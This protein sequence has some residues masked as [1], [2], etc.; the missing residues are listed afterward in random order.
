MEIEAKLK[1]LEIEYEAG[2][3]MLAEL[4]SKRERLTQAMLRIEGAMLV[5][6]ELIAGAAGKG[7][8]PGGGG[9]L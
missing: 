1:S 7:E 2:Q 3:R 9:A 6:R 4:E 5:L 8:P